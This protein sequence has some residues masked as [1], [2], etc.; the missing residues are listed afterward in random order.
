MNVKGQFP[1][2]MDNPLLFSTK[3]E[4]KKERKRERERERECPQVRGWEEQSRTSLQWL[5]A[6]LSGLGSWLHGLLLGDLEDLSQ[7]LSQ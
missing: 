2:Q 5:W 3:K 1:S 6:H 4:R 7:L